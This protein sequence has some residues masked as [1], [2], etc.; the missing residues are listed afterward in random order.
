MAGRGDDRFLWISFMVRPLTI[1]KFVRLRDR[2]WRVG[3]PQ[4]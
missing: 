1:S 4:A 2:V 3:L